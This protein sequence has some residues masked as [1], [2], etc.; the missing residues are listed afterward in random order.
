MG[1]GGFSVQSIIYRATDDLISTILISFSALPDSQTTKLLINGIHFMQTNM[2]A[3]VQQIY[4]K[5]RF[6]FLRLA[7]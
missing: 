5:S 2:L 4:I 1:V 6:E 3:A 7:F